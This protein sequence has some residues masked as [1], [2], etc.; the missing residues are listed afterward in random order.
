MKCSRKMV[1]NIRNVALVVVLGFTCGIVCALLIKASRDTAAE[2]RDR[3]YW[4][5]VQSGPRVRP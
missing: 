1:E 2:E 5:S 3:S 4:Q